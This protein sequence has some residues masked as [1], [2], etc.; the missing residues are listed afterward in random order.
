MSD[1]YTY[2][3]FWPTIPDQKKLFAELAD[4]LQTRWIGQGPKVTK[5]EDEFAAKFNAGWAVA[6]SSCT[7]ALHLAYRLAHIEPGDKVIS[8][9]L[10]C[11][12]ANHALLLQGAEILF[13]DIDPETLN[14]SPRHARLLCKQH[15]VRAIVPVHLG[16]QPCDIVGFSD[17]VTEY[18][19]PVI[20]D[21]AQALGA[22]YHGESIDAPLNCG[23]A[24]THSFQAI[25]HI[26]TGDGGM[27][28]V[29]PWRKDGAE[30]AKKLRWFAID[31]EAREKKYGWKPW[32]NRAITVDQTEL[33]YKYQMTDLD[34]CWGLVG[35][36]EVDANIE[37]RRQL[38]QTYRSQLLGF[39]GLTPLKEPDN[40]VCSY[41]LFGC[42]VERRDDFCEALEAKG[43]ETNVVQLRNDIYSVFGGKRLDNLEVMNEM[44]DKYI[45][46]PMNTKLHQ[47]DVAAICQ[48]VKEG[49]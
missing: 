46:L 40:T 42:L 11:T 44:E 39:D 28:C 21:A 4:T 34:A 10:T 31:R 3:L 29:P 13:C 23:F 38:A 35:L 48:L 15:E 27:I 14:P 41:S 49:W 6:T 47:D 17:L 1:K 7:A 26:T 18:E 2:P 5:F 9:V 12:A 25:K 36:Q 24:T 22:Q 37:Y 16:G 8:S 20:Y 32:A 45:Y 30:R 33:G 43:V 19:V